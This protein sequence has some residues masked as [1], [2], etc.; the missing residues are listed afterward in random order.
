MIIAQCRLNVLVPKITT[1]YLHIEVRSQN[2]IF[3]KLQI[4]N[5]R[6]AKY[7]VQVF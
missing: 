2:S 1:T 6:S 5:D 7:I 3:Q 4:P